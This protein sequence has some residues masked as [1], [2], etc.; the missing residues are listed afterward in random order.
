MGTITIGHR[1]FE[2]PVLI[3][4]VSSFETQLQPIEALL[5]QS[6]LQEPISLVSAYDVWLDRDQLPS[7]CK[8]FRR[9]GVL[10]LDSGGYESSRIGYYAGKKHSRRWNFSKYAKIADLDIYDFIFS[11]DYFLG[12]KETKNAFL[13][14]IIREFRRHADILDSKKLIPVVH[15]RSVDGTR[16]FSHKEVVELFG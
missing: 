15:V 14:R 1:S 5:L 6:T 9:Q 7:V 12:R 16:E 4:S 13:K 3:P 2:T 10:L 8:Q 11:Y